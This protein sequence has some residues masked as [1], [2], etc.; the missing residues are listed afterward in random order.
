MSKNTYIVFV[1]GR[2]HLDSDF[3]GVLCT[4]KAEDRGEACRRA[5]DL[6]P[7]LRDGQWL[8]ALPWNEMSRAD[9]ELHST[10]QELRATRET[11]RRSTLRN[12]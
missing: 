5:A 6:K 1:R 4:V 2:S 3:P 7:S 11:Q 8:E 10:W 12:A 9:H